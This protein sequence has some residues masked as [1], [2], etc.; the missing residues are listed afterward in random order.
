MHLNCTC[1]MALYQRT[2]FFFLPKISKLWELLS[3]SHKKGKKKKRKLFWWLLVNF[4]YCITS[5]SDLVHGLVQFSIW[6]D[7]VSVGIRRL[8][9]FQSHLDGQVQFTILSL[10][11]AMNSESRLHWKSLSRNCV[12]S[13]TADYHEPEMVSPHVFWKRNSTVRNT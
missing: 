6:N 7:L 9:N 8:S 2:G 11:T 12:E 5:P 1:V 10:I 13:Q 4:A 3:L